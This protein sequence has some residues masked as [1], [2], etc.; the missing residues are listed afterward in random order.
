M[1]SWDKILSDNIDAAFFEGAVALERE[2]HR[3]DGKII[4]VQKGTLALLREW[5]EATLSGPDIEAKVYQIV[6]PLRAVRSGRQHPA[7][8]FRKNSFSKDFH[9]QRRDVLRSIFQSLTELRTVLSELPGAEGVKAPKWLRE[10]RI[11]VF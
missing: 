11:D 2:V 6:G 7:H 5:L 9:E 8:R 3:N 1:L 10:E 4:V